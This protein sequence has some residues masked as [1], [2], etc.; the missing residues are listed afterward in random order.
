MND[1]LIRSKM[2]NLTLDISVLQY[3][4][5]A[6]PWWRVLR[7]RSIRRDIDELEHQLNMFEIDYESLLDA[8]MSEQEQKRLA[9]PS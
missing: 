3:D 4:L 6:T 5:V 7:N 2:M 8:V 9:D 1:K